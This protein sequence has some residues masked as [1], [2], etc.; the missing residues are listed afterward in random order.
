MR[1]LS[2]VHHQMSEPQGRDLPLAVDTYPTIVVVPE[3]CERRTVV[4]HDPF[5]HGPDDMRLITIQID[6]RSVDLVDCLGSRDRRLDSRP[7]ILAAE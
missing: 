1:S 7:H 2:E 5:L 3:S 6:F 4:P